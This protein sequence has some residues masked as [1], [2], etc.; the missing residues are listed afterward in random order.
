MLG[1]TTY[2]AHHLS[3]RKVMHALVVGKR[4]RKVYSTR[5]CEDKECFIV[6]VSRRTQLRDNAQEQCKKHLGLVGGRYNLR[7]SLSCLKLKGASCL[8]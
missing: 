2:G 3:I 5:C 7:E 4:I 1:Y 8:A 6:V